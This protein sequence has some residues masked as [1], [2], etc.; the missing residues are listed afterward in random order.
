MAWLIGWT[1]RK[2]KV[3]NGLTISDYQMK[4]NIHQ[5]TT[6]PDSST[7]IYL[8]GYIRSDF[9]DLR[10]TG[11]D[12]TT[13]L[14]YWIEPI[15]G[16]SPNQVAT[17]WIKIPTLTPGNNIYIYYNNPSATTL[18]NGNTTFEFFD[19]FSAL[20]LNKWTIGSSS[21]N[22]ASGY[23]QPTNLATEGLIYATGLN[24]DNFAIDYIFYSG[25]MVIPILMINYQN[26]NNF[27]IF[28][29]NTR[30]DNCATNHNSDIFIGSKYNGAWGYDYINFPGAVSETSYTW[31]KKS[32]TSRYDGTNRILEARDPATNNL[33]SSFSFPNRF[34]NGTIGFRAHDSLICTLYFDNIRVRKYISPEPTFGAS[35]NEEL[36]ITATDMVLDMTSCI[37]PCSINAYVTWH[38]YGNTDIASFTPKIIIDDIDSAVGTQI[39]IPAG[40]D[41]SSGI[42]TTPTLSLGSH[43]ICPYPN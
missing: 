30:Y 25:R 27:Y 23:L 34:N 41:A 9:A 42:I 18:S 17:V 33:I 15:S 2:V 36:N 16:T 20:N 10:F 21:W 8:G 39:S 31:T 12:G 37:G 29:D 3:V 22:V 24:I 26:Y 19:D 43:K 40:K 13:L 11:P 6:T 35:G 14:S 5:S 4:L 1:R 38:N 7:D 32:I 28:G